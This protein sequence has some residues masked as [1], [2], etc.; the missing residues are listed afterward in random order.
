[1]LPEGVYEGMIEV[2]TLNYPAYLEIP[3]QMTMVVGVQDAPIPGE[4]WLGQ[5]YPN[6]FNPS[7]TIEVDLGA[8]RPGERPRLLLHDLLGRE[9][10]DVSSQLQSRPGRQ[11]ITVDASSLDGGVYR[12]TLIYGSSVQTRSMLVIK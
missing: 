9:I 3:V 10:A 8:I 11:I 2:R 1:V 4:V 12:Y 7:T 6:P 5:N